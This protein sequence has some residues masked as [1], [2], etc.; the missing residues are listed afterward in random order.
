MK[1][2]TISKKKRK[3]RGNGRN[4]KN[5]K[6]NT[7]HIR[8]DKVMSGCPICNG[9]VLQLD[10]IELKVAVKS[11]MIYKCFACSRRY[12]RVNG[13]YK[14]IFGNHVLNKKRQVNVQS[15]GDKI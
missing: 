13:S 6:P 7:L 9:A 4:G 3:Y 15:V 2:V 10:D 8:K 12:I 1:K 14:Y 5:G 11:N